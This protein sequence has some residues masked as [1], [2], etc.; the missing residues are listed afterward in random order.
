MA[1]RGKK[2]QLKAKKS[3]P[4]GSPRRE[5]WVKPGV[6][7]EIG[8]FKPMSERGEWGTDEWCDRPMD[9]SWKE[10]WIGRRITC[11]WQTMTL[12]SPQSVLPDPAIIHR[13]SLMHWSAR[14][15]P[16]TRRC[17]TLL[18]YIVIDQELIPVERRVILRTTRSR[19]LSVRQH[20]IHTKISRLQ[21]GQ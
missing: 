5:S 20:R 8:G 3:N 15:S 13:D 11:L 12:W 2:N 21:P 4:G 1:S 6:Y 7:G 19:V 16:E 17:R 9:R 14:V 10:S 18:L